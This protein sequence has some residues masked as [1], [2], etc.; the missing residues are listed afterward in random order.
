VERPD[1]DIHQNRQSQGQQIVQA[2]EAVSVALSTH[3]KPAQQKRLQAFP[4]NDRTEADA[5]ITLHPERHL[6]P[7]RNIAH[8]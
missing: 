7:R 3:A 1:V 2:E 8:K 4:M 6:T 5:V